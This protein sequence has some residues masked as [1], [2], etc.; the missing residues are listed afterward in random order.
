MKK[1]V[2][3]TVI[4]Q[5]IYHGENSE[6]GVMADKKVYIKDDLHSEFADKLESAEELFSWFYGRCFEDHHRE[7]LK[8]IFNHFGVYVRA[9]A[10]GEGEVIFPDMEKS[11]QSSG[12]KLN[13]LKE[14]IEDIRGKMLLIIDDYKQDIRID[15]AKELY[16]LVW[17]L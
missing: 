9:L 15:E 3:K 16:E 13:K 6:G 2:V 7:F 12:E 14:N 5:L 11:R 4:I 8:V 10:I 1:K 17:E